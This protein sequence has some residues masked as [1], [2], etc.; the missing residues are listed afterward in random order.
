MTIGI[1]CRSARARVRELP[2]RRLGDLGDLTL[3]QPIGLSRSTPSAAAGRG[4]ERP[5]CASRRRASR[6]RPRAARRRSRART[7]RPPSSGSPRTAGA[8][9]RAPP[10]HPPAPAAARRSPAPGPRSSS[11]TSGGGSSA[12]VRFASSVS[13]ISVSRPALSATAER[14][15]LS[16]SVRS[17]ARVGVPERLGRRLGIAGQDLAQPELR[18]RPLGIGRRGPLQDRDRLGVVLLLA[19]AGRRAAATSPATPASSASACRRASATSPLSERL[20]GRLDPG[21]APLACRLVFLLVVRF[22]RHRPILRD[23]IGRVRQHC[24]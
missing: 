8:G 11:R 13:P 22:A 18:R 3:G 19:T 10:R 7:R 21:I 24:Q 15:S 2:Q 5:G 12:S 14:N 20:P 1:P 6:S 17:S 9:G 23:Q 4:V 16:S